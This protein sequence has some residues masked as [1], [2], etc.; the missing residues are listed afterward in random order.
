[1][2]VRLFFFFESPSVVSV[3]FVKTIPAPV[4][5]QVPLKLPLATQPSGQ[6]GGITPKSVPGTGPLA[7]LKVI[8]AID[9]EAVPRSE[10][11]LYCLI[12]RRKK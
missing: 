2:D 11:R 4:A 1:M 8:S 9:R 12:E 5:D 6:A 10:T 7:I 3:P